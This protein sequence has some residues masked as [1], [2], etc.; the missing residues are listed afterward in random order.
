[1]VLQDSN[2]SA[3]IRAAAQAIAVLC[4][5]PILDGEQS[6]RIANAGVLHTARAQI[7]L[8][9]YTHNRV[10]PEAIETHCPHIALFLMHRGARALQFHA[11][12]AINTMIRDDVTQVDERSRHRTLS[13]SNTRI[14]NTSKP[15]GG[16]SESVPT[17]CRA[18]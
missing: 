18:S 17:S 10:H 2:E 12:H 13:I 16:P 1:M 8:T 5:R 9:R 4:N 14:L 15:C 6:Y 3:T 7:V 11:R